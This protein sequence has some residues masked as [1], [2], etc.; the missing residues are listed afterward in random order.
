MKEVRLIC[1]TTPKLSHDTGSCL[2]PKLRIYASPQPLQIA[3]VSACALL[4]SFVTVSIFIAIMSTE[5]FCETLVAGGV[6]VTLH[7][8]FTLY[9]YYFVPLVRWRHSCQSL[10]CAL[11]LCGF[12]MC[13][14]GS[15]LS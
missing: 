1:P 9:S 2:K 7:Y 13:A 11:D 5:L 4:P 14:F 12:G 3:F 8:R 15:D 10:E 6:T